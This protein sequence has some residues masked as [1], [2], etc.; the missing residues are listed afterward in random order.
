[1]VSPGEH[2]V[3][4]RLNSTP[5]PGVQD[6]EFRI[7]VL[8]VPETLIPQSLGPKLFGFRV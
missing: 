3:A 4:S 1:M 8:G 7:W 2:P 5:N 6:L